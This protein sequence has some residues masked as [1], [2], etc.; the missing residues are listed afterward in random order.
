[1]PTSNRPRHRFIMLEHRGQPLLSRADF[2][3]RAL[4][5]VAGA[6]LVIL[7]AL[8]AGMLGYHRFEQLSWLDSFLNAR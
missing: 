2:V 5:Y 8:G 1:M 6:L 7:I 4:G 3:K